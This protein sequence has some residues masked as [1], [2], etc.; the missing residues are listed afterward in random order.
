MLSVRE[1]S[2]AFCNA[3]KSGVPCS[4]STTISPSSQ[5]DRMPSASTAAASGFIRSVQS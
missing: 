1:A 4:P 5:A 2:N 3:L